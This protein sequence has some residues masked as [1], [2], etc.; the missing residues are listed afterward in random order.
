M[1]AS[2]L[3]PVDSRWEPVFLSSGSSPASRG[4]RWVGH[5]A[6]FIT[7][8]RIFGSHERPYAVAVGHADLDGGVHIRHGVWGQ[9]G[10]RQVQIRLAGVARSNLESASRASASTSALTWGVEGEFAVGTHAVQA[11]S[12]M[13][14]RRRDGMRVISRLFVFR[15]S[16]PS[17]HVQRITAGRRAHL[18]VWMIECRETYRFS[19]RR[20]NLF[21][22]PTRPLASRSSIAGG[23]TKQKPT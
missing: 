8:V 18:R 11:A 10:D 14:A 23:N 17:T 12:T 1:R 6:C 16:N 22:D 21:R 7:G 5:R 4:R 19:P 9:C 13:A 2:P 20:R 3:P 15:P